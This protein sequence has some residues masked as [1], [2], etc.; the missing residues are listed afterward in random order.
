[1]SDMSELIDKPQEPKDERPDQP[2]AAG[3]DRPADDSPNNRE[4]LL[5]DM[6]Q[7]PTSDREAS[8]PEIVDHSDAAGLH[9]A[10]SDPAGEVA[11]MVFDDVGEIAEQTYESYIGPGTGQGIGHAIGDALSWMW[12]GRELILPEIKEKAKEAGHAVG[13]SLSQLGESAAESMGRMDNAL[14]PEQPLKSE[15]DAHLARIKGEA[16]Q[17]THHP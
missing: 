11:D 8:P 2:S 12:M 10:D 6:Q 1:M 9:T 13:E 3:V 5:P 17:H 14:S 16:E 4:D 7:L 15:I